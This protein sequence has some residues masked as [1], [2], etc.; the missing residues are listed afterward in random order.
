M[1]AFLTE[2]VA[3]EVLTGTGGEEEDRSGSGWLAVCI[4]CGC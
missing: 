2:V 4:S 3:L 1:T